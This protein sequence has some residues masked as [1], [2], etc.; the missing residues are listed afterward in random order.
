[1]KLI[2]SINLIENLMNQFDLNFNLEMNQ[3]KLKVKLKINPSI[4]IKLV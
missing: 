3:L 2:Y 1:M 4:I